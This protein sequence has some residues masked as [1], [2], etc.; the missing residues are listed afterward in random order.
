MNDMILRGLGQKT[1]TNLDSI[2]PLTAEAAVR[3]R[4]ELNAKTNPMIEMLKT[5]GSGKGKGTPGGGD[6]GADIEELFRRGRENRSQAGKRE[7]GQGPQVPGPEAEATEV[8]G[9]PKSLEQ[10]SRDELSELVGKAGKGTIVLTQE[11]LDR[12]VQLLDRFLSEPK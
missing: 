8:P 3:I 2:D 10:M 5:F 12:A 11:Q 7:P 9:Q 6:E 1:G 4:S